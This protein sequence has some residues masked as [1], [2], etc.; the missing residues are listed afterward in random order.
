MTAGAARDT[1]DSRVDRGPA[2]AGQPPGPGLGVCYASRLF[3]KRGVMSQKKLKVGVLGATGMVGQR[4]VALLENHPWFEVT[5]VAASAN[6]AGPEVRRRRE[7]ALG[8]RDRDPGRDRRPHRE[9]RVGHRRDRRRRST[10]SSAPS[11]CPR[12]RRRSSRRTTRAR[13]TPVVSNNSAHRGTPDVPMMIPEVNPEHVGGHRG[14][15]QAARH[16]ARLHRGEAELLDPELRPGDPPAHGVRAEARSR[17]APTRRSA[18][19]GRPSR[20][21][22]R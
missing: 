13:E 9:E 19:R 6:S 21:G 5:L 4:F 11:T 15:A 1:L 2:P 20:A 17:S 22:R 14:A 16:H 7:G 3:P 12:T 10:S 8:A 18:A